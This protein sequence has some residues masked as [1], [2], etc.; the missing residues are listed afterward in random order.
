MK[1]LTYPFVLLILLA[2]CTGDG[3]PATAEGVKTLAEKLRTDRDNE[4][5]QTLRPSR[6]DALAICSSEDAANQLYKYTEEMYT[7]IPED[8]I[9]S[10]EEQTVIMVFSCTTD[11]MK[12]K[13]ENQLPDG[14]THVA[15]N[16]KNGLTFYQFKYV[17]PGEE[18]GLSYDAL[19]YINNHWVLLPKSFRAF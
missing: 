8:A 1:R 17:A 6:A 5:L 19:V 15:E 9:T 4:F 13:E 11:Q 2:A 18:L 12:K 14:Y 10:G 7:S 16:W 3:I